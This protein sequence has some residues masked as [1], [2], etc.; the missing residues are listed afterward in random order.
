MNLRLAGIKSYFNT[1]LGPFLT[2]VVITVGQ[3]FI[4]NAVGFIGGGFV[5]LLPLITAVLL[6]LSIFAYPE[7]HDALTKGARV[8][9]ITGIAWLSLVNVACM[10]WFISDM[11]NPQ[12][13]TV[14]HELLMAGAAL[15]IVNVGIFAL[16][17][18]ELDAGG[19]EMRSLGR[20]SIFKG[21]E[22]ET[23][24]DFVFPQQEDSDGHL[25]PKDWIPGFTDYL[26]TS[27]S[28]A[29]SFAPAAATPYSRMSKIMV[30]LETLISFVTIGLIIARAISL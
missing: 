30:G 2:V 16:A 4:A 8:L 19:P 24:P 1:R 3:V 20:P 27:I 5:W 21:G 28:T 18:W 22:K 9:S 26:Y 7:A 23:Y 29:T 6:L 15:W 14:A 10:A 11:L 17:Y 13:V 12:T 25:A